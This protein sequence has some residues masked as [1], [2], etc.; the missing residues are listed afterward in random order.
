MTQDYTLNFDS[1]SLG[2]MLSIYYRR[3]F[4]SYIFSKWIAYGEPGLSQ[5]FKNREFSFTIENDIYV[6]YQSFSN[7]IEFERELIR[8]CP[9]K[10]DIGAVYSIEPKSYQL[11]RSGSFQP[12]ERELIFDIDLSD[13][14]D[15]RRCCRE[16]AVCTKCW[17]LMQIAVKIIDASIREDFGYERILWVFSGRRGIHCWVCDE[18]ARKLSNRV[19]ESI[20]DYLSIVKWKRW[21]V[22]TCFSAKPD[23]SPFTTRFKDNRRML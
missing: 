14:D 3:I 19:R 7:H 5:S 17:P 4:P 8:M 21:L 18:A 13:Y 22:Q 9:F 20:V 1:T 11:I 12:I 2:Q 16:G 15:V 6:R 23:T 10:M